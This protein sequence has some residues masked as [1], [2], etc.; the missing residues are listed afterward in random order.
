VPLATAQVLQLWQPGGLDQPLLPV[1]SLEEL[2]VGKM[3]ALLGRSAPRDV[4]DIAN[5]P[6]PAVRVTESPLFRSLFMAL[7]ITLEHPL[8]TYGKKHIQHSLSENDIAHQLVPMLLAKNAWNVIKHLF[9]LNKNESELI[10]SA[11]HGL[12]RPELLFHGDSELAQRIASHPA[13]LWK[14]NN[15]R[16]HLNRTSPETTS[17]AL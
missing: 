16:A 10:S 14:I 15:V 9:V 2:I 4:W 6:E 11:E 5:L 13:L 8:K 12:L 1:V 7:A 17:N 3:L